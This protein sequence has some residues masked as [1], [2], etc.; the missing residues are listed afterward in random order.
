[1]DTPFD[2][3]SIGVTVVTVQD[4]Q[5]A[6]AAPNKTFQ[7]LSHSGHEGMAGQREDTGKRVV[8]VSVAVV[9]DRGHHQGSLRR[10]LLCRPVGH[11]LTEQRV[12]ADGEMWPV[13]FDRGS[14]KY[15]YCMGGY[16]LNLVASH[17]RQ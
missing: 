11:C 4:H 5:L 8:V 10:R 14:G 13:L 6:K 1:M 3:I 17:F 16:V 7:H 9:E 15:R 2:G 12:G